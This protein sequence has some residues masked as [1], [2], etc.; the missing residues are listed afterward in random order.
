MIDFEV[1]LLAAGL[2]MLVKGA[3]WFVC[4]TSGIAARYGISQLVIGLTVVAMGTSAPEASVSIT[5]ALNNSADITMGNIVGSNILNILIILGI[6]ALV[7]PIGI[8]RSTIRKDIPFLIVITILFLIFA[9]TGNVV[10]IF[11]G[12][13]FIIIFILYML[14]LFKQS[15]KNEYNAE[16]NHAEKKMAAWKMWA[17]AVIGL[18]VVVIGSKI[19]VN[20]AKYIAYEAGM[21]EKFIGLT[22][23]A[24]GTSLPELFTSVLAA[25]RGK[26]D[27]AIGNIVGSNVFNILAV[28][29]ISAVI[30]PVYCKQGFAFDIGVAVAS[31]FL[32]LVLAIRKKRLN[33]IS[34]LIMLTAYAVYFICIIGK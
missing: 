32:L 24:L 25:I 14:Y 8:N 22:I 31:A 26:A 16:E 11:E 30:T 19:T 4:G 20:S 2:F 3:D 9:A 15:K 1:L 23:V 27:I 10:N 33:R 5:A 21:S 29:G 18:A 6:T 17:L 28:I 12:A 34:G 7:A 13:I